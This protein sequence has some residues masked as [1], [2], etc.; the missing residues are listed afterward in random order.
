MHGGTGC[1]HQHTGTS[2][3]APLAAGMLA[4]AIEANPCLTWRDFKYLV[5]LTAVKVR[6]VLPENAKRSCCVFKPIVINIKISKLL[7]KFQNGILNVVAR[8]IK[9]IRITRGMR[10]VCTTVI[11]TA[12][13]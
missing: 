5:I 9:S 10:L 3:A 8:W 13:V 2:A 7:L 12:L 4:L 11:S 1:T 6:L